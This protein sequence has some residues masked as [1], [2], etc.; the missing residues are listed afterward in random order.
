MNTGTTQRDRSTGIEQVQMPVLLE[1][2]QAM[3]GAILVNS[4]AYHLVSTFLEE[5]HF[6]EPLHQRIFAAM[7]NRI[8]AGREIDARIMRADLMDIANESIGEVTVGQY[9]IRLHTSATTIVNAK[10]FAQSIV[11]NWKQRHLI[12]AALETFDAAK[13]IAVLDDVDG[14]LEELSEK[15]RE[16][17]FSGTI[18]NVVNIG[19]AARRSVNE[20]TTAFQDDKLPGYSSGFQP[21]DE[22][23]GRFRHG[24]LFVLLSPSGGGKSIMASQIM[25]YIAKHYAPTYYFQMEMEAVDMARR[26]LASASKVKTSEQE[27]GTLTMFDFENIIE[28]QQEMANVP[29]YIDESPQLKMSQ[30]EARMRSA[31]RLYGTKVFAV[32]HVKLIKPEHRRD[33][34]VYT[35]TN[36]ANRL[37]ALAKEL[38]VSVLLLAQ[39]TRESQKRDDTRPRISDIYGGGD[40]EEISDAICAIHNPRV[41]LLE[42]A[43]NRNSGDD[44]EKWLN[45]LDKW[46][47]KAEMRS[48]KRRRGVKSQW[49]T[50]GFDG[51]NAEF[52]EL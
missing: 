17:Q 30:I 51:A 26:A 45:Q 49:R 15:L 43:P 39:C 32:D 11:A 38:K 7:V 34:K 36:S 50:I 19:E 44:F 48:M 25:H 41:T 10:D 12:Q 24:D 42:R 18:P 29:F 6:S 13:E 3:L 52:T 27:E 1:A 40:V 46:N 9:I 35:I 31:C 16:I 23:I 8:S 14:M 37:K 21:W 2:E 5:K 22:N 47:G 28:A 20:T 33:D 4:D